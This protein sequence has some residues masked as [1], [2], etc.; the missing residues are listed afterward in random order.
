MSLLTKIIIDVTH[1]RTVRLQDP[2]HDPSYPADLVF[3]VTVGLR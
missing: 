1:P 3:V 2:L